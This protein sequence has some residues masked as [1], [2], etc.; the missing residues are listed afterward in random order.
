MTLLEEPLVTFADVIL[1][2]SVRG[3]YTYRVPMEMEGRF[4]LGVE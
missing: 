4:L 3:Y 1:P 2:L